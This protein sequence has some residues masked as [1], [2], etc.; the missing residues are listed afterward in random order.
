MDT[1]NPLDLPGPQFLIVFGGLAL[2]GFV[3]SVMLRRR[4]G[5]QS[6]GRAINLDPFE[7]AHL[8]GGNQLALNTALASLYRRDLVAV[9]PD[10]D[11]LSVSSD[12][13][14][15]FDLH[16]VEREAYAT[17]ERLGAASAT[18]VG[19]IAK[20]MPTLSALDARIRSLGLRFGPG[21]YASHGIKAAVPILA[22]IALGAIKI[23]M[24]L[25]RGYPVAFLVVLVVIT[26]LVALWVM[27]SPP[28]RTRLGD[29]AL[30]D[31]RH[32]HAALESTA[33]AAPSSLGAGQ[34]AMAF[35]LFGPAILIGSGFDPLRNI[36]T[37]PGTSSASTCS[38]S[39]SSS[40]DSGGGDS[41]GG[42][43]CGGCGGGGGD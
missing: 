39:S 8:A 25:Q 37:P 23:A 14:L 43:G 9:D 17:I 21:E 26:L 40:S 34:L 22:V 27:F 16:P 33:K 4:A 35:A 41:G 38:G 18:D 30:A 20:G 28:Q 15:P 2:A 19:G 13:S 7:V 5:P 1:L 3:L 42:G 32:R 10:G 36:I 6:D 24:G 31:A 29:R 12:R 11:T